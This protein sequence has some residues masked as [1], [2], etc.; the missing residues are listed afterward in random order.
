MEKICKN[1]K[2]YEEDKVIPRR[3]CIGDC[4][5]EKFDYISGG[6]KTKIDGI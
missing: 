1:C 4:F 5:C 2:N 3:K 6:E